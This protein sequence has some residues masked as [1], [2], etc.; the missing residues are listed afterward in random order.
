MELNGA[1][2]VTFSLLSL[3]KCNQQINFFFLHIYLANVNI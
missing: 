1:F 2:L 3:A